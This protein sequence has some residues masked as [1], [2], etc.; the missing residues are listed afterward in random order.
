MADPKERAPA[1][2]T[3]PSSPGQ[4]TQSPSPP[5]S[6]AVSRRSE[7]PPPAAKKPRSIAG[8]SRR[9]SPSADRGL[10]AGAPPLDPSLYINRELSWLE[11][12]Q[13][14]LDEANDTRHPLLERVK[15][16]SIVSSN[17]DEFFMVR[18]AAIKEQILADVVEY[19]PD[20]RTPLQQLK[21]IHERASLMFKHMSSCFWDDVHP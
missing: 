13:R 19:S 11:F 7:A 5:D 18:V 1:Q 10:G 21:A 3:S 8:R 15:L 20:G 6:H 16:L 14:V 17:L 4:G 12:N 9:R 2:E